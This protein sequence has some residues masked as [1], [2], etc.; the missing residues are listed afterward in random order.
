LGTRRNIKGEAMNRPVCI[1]GTRNFGK[2]GKLIELAEKHFCYLVVRDWRTA[3]RIEEQIRKEGRKMPF[4]LTYNEF[5]E[6]KFYGKGINC[7]II[8]DVETLLRYLARGRK[9]RGFSVDAGSVEIINLD[10]ER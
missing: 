6:G 7:F 5:I 10:D 1:I 4:P 2:T 8:D 9:V 3:C